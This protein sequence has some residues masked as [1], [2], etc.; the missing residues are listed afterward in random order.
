MWTTTLLIIYLLIGVGAFSYGLL[1]KDYDFELALFVG[2]FYP[3][4]CLLY[5]LMFVLAVFASVAH[6]IGES[7]RMA[8]M[9]KK[10]RD[11]DVN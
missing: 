6:A 4:I 5:A 10:A 11:K 8:K 7:V 1:R 3:L 2:I 9:N